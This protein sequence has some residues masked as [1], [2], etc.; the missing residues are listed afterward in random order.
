MRGLAAALLVA[1]CLT[2]PATPAAARPSFGDRV[3]VAVDR[4]TLDTRIGDH[5]GFTTTV[6]NHDDRP[7]TGLVAHLNVLSVEPDVYVDPEDWSA[8][9]TVYLDPIP[10]HGSVRVPWQV[11]AVNEGRF[12]LY[13]AV[14]TRHGPAPVAVSDGLWLSSA[15]ARTIGSVGVLP[16]VLGVPG[17]VALLLVLNAAR[18]RRTT[19]VRTPS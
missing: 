17:A 3:T 6:S 10:A 15:G 1:L 18:R 4:S 11:Q 16:V 7:M 9:R 12:V 8:Q 13:V 19:R 2:T 14:T 5:F